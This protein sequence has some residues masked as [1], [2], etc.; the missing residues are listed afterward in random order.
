MKAILLAAGEGL[1]LRPLTETTPKPLLKVLGEPI[2]KRSISGLNKYGIESFIIITN[3][4]EEQIKEY[5]EK[6]FPK[7]EIDFVHQKEI[8]GTANALVLAKDKIREDFLIA[9]NGD[10]VYSD[11]L[12]RK[13]VEAAQ[14]KIISVGGKFTE[15]ITK[16]GAIILDS[17]KVPVKMIEKPSK[18]EMEEGY[19]N[20]GIYSLSR[21]IFDIIEVME[22]KNS[23]SPRGEYEIPDA[24][25]SLLEMKKYSAQLV[26]LKN[27]DYWFDIGRPWNLLDANET[28]ISYCKEEREGTIE[29]GATLKGKIIIKKDAIIRSGV[30]IEGPVFIDEG[31]DIGPNCYIRSCTYLGKKSRIGNGCE[32]K[33]SII[34]DNSHAAH[35]S[36]IGDSIIGPRCNF[37]AGT[38]TANLRLDKKTIPVKIKGNKEDSQRRKLGVIIGEGV[39]TG[40]GALLMPGVKIGS[41][42][43]VG[44]GT[45]VDE[46]IPSESIYFGTQKYTLRRKRKNAN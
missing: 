32:I 29:S 46:D 37:G 12:I 28:L 26:E 1:R 4:L 42:S 43:W 18:D 19:A 40:I 11:S 44:A 39:E 13:T 9:V 36:Y 45:I 24:V 20:I 16:Y 21:E 8:K 6:E 10:C 15:E 34:E 7:L 23:I 2:L 17:N 22:K 35:L 38:I 3:Y 5:I 14:K 30:Y 33:N 27:D 25:N 41:N 31:A